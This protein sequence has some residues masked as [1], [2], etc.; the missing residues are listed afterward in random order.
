MK[1]RY[2][3]IAIAV[4]LVI[5]GVLVYIGIAGASSNTDLF[6]QSDYPVKYSLKKGNMVVKLDGHRSR[7]L[8][9]SFDITD[10]TK[11]AVAQ[12]GFEFNGKAKYIITPKEEGLTRVRFF[13]TRNIAGSDIN[14]AEI[15]MPIFVT[16][17]NGVLNVTFLSDPYLVDAPLIIGEATA[18]PVFIEDN[19]EGSSVIRFANG[20]GD[21][22]VENPDNVLSINISADGNRTIATLSKIEN[23]GADGVDV[24]NTSIVLSSASLEVRE[25]L[26]VTFENDG[27]VTVKRAETSTEK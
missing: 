14:V 17:T 21:W 11:V 12:S 13:R 27:T 24:H 8:K 15:H 9:W 5:L 26:A 20:Q 2:F 25:E 19:E 18:N 23:A 6:A 1:K 10:D 4:L 22:G 7:D 3:I 16:N